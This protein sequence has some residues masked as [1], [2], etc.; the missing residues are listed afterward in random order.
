MRRGYSA[1]VI[2]VASVVHP[3]QEILMADQ[4]APPSGAL[5]TSKTY[6]ATFKT[7]KGDIVVAG[8]PGDEATVKTYARKGNRVVLEPAGALAE[9]GCRHRQ[10]RAA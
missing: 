10:C 9:G 7:E 4:L 2:G 1:S 8:I 5:D 3:P 6:T